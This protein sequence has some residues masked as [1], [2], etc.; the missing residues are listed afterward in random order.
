MPELDTSNQV[1]Q[2]LAHAL[3]TT[4]TYHTMQFQY[5]WVCTPILTPE[6]IAAGQDLG[7][8]KL[9]VDS[10]TGTVSEYPSWAPQMVAEDYS[11]AIESGQVPQARQLYPRLWRVSFHRIQE[12]TNTIEYQVREQSLAQPP[13][14][15]EDYRLTIDKHTLAYQPT[16]PRF[17]THVVSWTEWHNRHNGTWP[18][19]EMFEQ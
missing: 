1:Q 6:E 8:T 3:N 18:D 11:Q 16:A 14:P 9:V 13:E 15:T 7:L 10:R 2:Y 19:Q 4:S 12:N 5:G 17:A